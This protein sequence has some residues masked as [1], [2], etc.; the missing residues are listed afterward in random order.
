MKKKEILDDM[1][2][3]EIDEDTC[4]KDMPKEF[5]EDDDNKFWTKQS[6]KE[7]TRYQNRNFKYFKK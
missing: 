3:F 4:H 1:D 7:R 6:I 2:D 5:Y